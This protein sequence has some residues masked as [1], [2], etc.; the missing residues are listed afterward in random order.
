MLL[1]RR[2]DDAEG[3][4]RMI[5]SGRRPDFLGRFTRAGL[6]VTFVVAEA[7]CPGRC[8]LRLKKTS[9]VLRT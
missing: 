4:R 1:M 2:R 8:R 7:W 5:G 9:A 6:A 3:E